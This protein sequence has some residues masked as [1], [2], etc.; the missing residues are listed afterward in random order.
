VGLF[1]NMD[2]ISSIKGLKESDLVA[3]I[4]ETFVTRIIQLIL[5]LGTSV[6]L[7]RA[8]GPEG[9]GAFALAATLSAVII[10]IANLGL[11]SANTYYSARSHGGQ[12]N[13]LTGN[14]L[15]ISLVLLLPCLLIGLF[16]YLIEEQSPVTGW[17]LILALIGAP[18]GLLY[19]N[20][21]NIILGLQEVRSINVTELKLNFLT[22][23][24]LLFIAL[25]GFKSPGPMYATTIAAQI[26]GV[27]LL[28]IW[29]RKVHSVKPLVSL[30][31]LKKSLSYGFKAYIATLFSF[32]VFRVDI[33][34]V[35]HYHG[36]METG[37]YA[38]A[39]TLVNM[40]Y[41]L[42]TVAGSL[43]FAKMC[44]I[45]SFQER[46]RL[47]IRYS[48]GI[49][50][51]MLIA[52]IAAIMLCSFFIKL[53]FG[54]EY[55]ASADAFI[56]LMPGVLAW[57]GESIIRKV[58]TSDGYH[59]GVVNNWGIAFVVNV[60]LNVLLIPENGI[61]GAAIASSTAVTL[62]AILNIVLLF[63]EWRRNNV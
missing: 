1:S 46:V 7:A 23:I 25:V 49:S 62:V 21:Q 20:L 15:I 43:V 41:I 10:Q 42:P 9:R 3:K 51:I 57:S 19:M 28:F 50:A 45:P 54:D 29:I 22:L 59:L 44:G 6:L 5:S 38:I 18:V 8:L 47:G 33:L 24:G 37:L 34:M 26:Y 61:Q 27:Y 35:N 63:W 40:M 17:L 14:A 4:S 31:L 13:G 36:E 16:L 48:L 55:A 58:L 11:H 12:L 30:A 2:L 56:L 53:L 39:L 32:L 52:V 60:I